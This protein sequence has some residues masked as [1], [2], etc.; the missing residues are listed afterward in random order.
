[1]EDTRKREKINVEKAEGRTVA[2]NI[3][4][5]FGIF[6]LR[7]DAIITSTMIKSLMRHK[8]KEIYVYEIENENKN[9]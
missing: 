5:E 9:E 1:M 7:K 2:E 4:N 8:V 3:Y 6:L